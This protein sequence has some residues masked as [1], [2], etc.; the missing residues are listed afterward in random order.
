[1]LIVALALILA[2]VA[3]QKWV[4]SNTAIN[5]SNVNDGSNVHIQTG[6]PAETLIDLAKKLGVAESE[7]DA[8]MQKYRELESQ[9]ANRTDDLAK[10]AQAFLA[11]GR[12]QDAEQLFKQALDNDL[13]NAAS[14]AFSLAGIKALQLNYPEAKRYYQQAVQLEPDNAL[15]LNDLG[16]QLY[17]MGEYAQAEPLYQRSLAILENALG[18]DH[19]TVATS[20]NNLAGLYDTQGQYAQAEP[21]YQRSL[22]ILENALGKD[23]PDVAT[24]LNNLTGL[25]DTQG[26]YAQAEPL[27]QRSLVILENAL[28]KDHPNTQTV[29]A[30]L[31]AMR[32]HVKP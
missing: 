24:S 20:L 31:Q 21:L 13:K 23:H 5:V 1:L 4:G 6:I 8:W 16:Y 12:L 14:N 15:Y 22:V 2:G 27:Y 7:R 9:L 10:Q 26:Q 3:L 30:N 25:Y 19:P 32:A 28:G 17:T 11:E 29:R 18:K